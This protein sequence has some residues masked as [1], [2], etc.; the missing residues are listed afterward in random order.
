M[1]KEGRQAAVWNLLQHEI[2]R[3]I[4]IGGDGS[5]TGADL[6]RREWKEHLDQLVKDGKIK[7]EVAERRSKLYIVGIVGSI[8]NDMCGTD[9]TIGAGKNLI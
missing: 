4:C 7:P 3:L 1:T 9:N 8:D 6:L 5:L 2:D